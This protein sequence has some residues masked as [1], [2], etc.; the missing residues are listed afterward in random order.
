[1]AQ[2]NSPKQ[3]VFMCVCG[4]GGVINEYMAG[5]IILEAFSYHTFHITREQLI[6]QYSS[7]LAQE[8]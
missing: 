2:K 6:T 7:S 1:M 4:G 5:Y 8:S 3:Q